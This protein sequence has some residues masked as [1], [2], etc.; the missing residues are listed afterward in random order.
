MKEFS[1]PLDIKSLDIISQRYD[2][3]GNIVFTVK[4]N[5]EGTKC[6]KCG[7]H[8]KIHNGYAPTI[9]VR[10]LPILDIPVYLKIQPARYQCE[11]CD[12]NTTTTE[13][14]DWC[15]RRSSTTKGLDAYVARCL[16]NSTIADVA[17]KERLGYKVVESS[18]N[19]QISK[20]VDWNSYKDLHTVGVDEISMKKGHQEFVVVISARTKA[21]KLSVIAVLPDRKKETVLEFFKSIPEHLRKTVKTVCTDMYD[22]FVYPATEIFGKQAVV[23]DRYHVSKLYRQPLD[24]LRIKEMKRLKKELSHEE[25]TK[26][27]GMMWILRKQHECLSEVDKAALE[28]LYTYSPL[29]KSAHSY[30]LKLTHIFNTHSN[31]KDAMAKIDRWIVSVEESNLTCFNTFI[32]TL[33]KYKSGIMNYFKSRKNSGFVEGLNNKI[34]VI[35]RRCYGFFKVES[36]F[37][38]LVLD[39]RGFDIFCSIH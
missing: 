24:V 34:K 32:K 38:R 36:L 33:I 31:R 3:K 10:H 11:Y 13:Q 22:G 15:E 20:E 37:Q 17:R 1:L 18:I 12:D 8:A 19:R 30:A 14:Y 27:E 7:K 35:K 6:H 9:E 39:L 16:I 2:N 21:G 25:Y 26:L 4:S 28:A 23:V 29:L 5:K